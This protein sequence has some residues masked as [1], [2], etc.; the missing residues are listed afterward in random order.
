MHM[1]TVERTIEVFWDCF[2][3]TMYFSAANVD[4]QNKKNSKQ[5]TKQNKKN[6][7]E[8]LVIHVQTIVQKPLSEQ[9]CLNKHI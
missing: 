6:R 1:E 9:C 5:K 4:F 3:T 2:M 7:R 8:K